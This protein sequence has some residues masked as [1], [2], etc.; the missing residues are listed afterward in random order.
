M[1][2]EEALDQ[3][4]MLE[5]VFDSVCK[6]TKEKKDETSIFLFGEKGSPSL[7]T[8]K[9]LFIRRSANFGNVSPF[10]SRGNKHTFRAYPATLKI[11]ELSFETTAAHSTIIWSTWLG[12]LPLWRAG[13]GFV[14]ILPLP[15]ILELAENTM[16]IAHENNAQ[17]WIQHSTQDLKPSANINMHYSLAKSITGCIKFTKRGELWIDFWQLDDIF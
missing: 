17:D 13:T 1:S 6:K 7:R 3:R 8:T 14:G 12:F 4:W 11:A 5:L 9:S 2:V 10:H 15:L 16:Y